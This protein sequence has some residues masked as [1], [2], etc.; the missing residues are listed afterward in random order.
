MNVVVPFATKSP[1]LRGV[2][3]ALDQDG[4]EPEYIHCDKEDSYYNV[5]SKYWSAKED[6]CVVEHDIIVWPGALSELSQCPEPWCTF[7]YYCSVGWIIDGLGCTKF[8]KHLLETYPN[9]LKEPFPTCCSHSRNYCG[10]DRL[11]A[12]KALELG[13]KPHVHK[14]GVTNLNEKWT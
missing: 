9:F 12:H 3:L 2:I 8:S 11:I 7:P 5:M 14:P 4:W 1:M 6:F 13:L 10:L